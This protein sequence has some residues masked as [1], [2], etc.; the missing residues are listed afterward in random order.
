MIPRPP[1][2]TLFPYT[3]L[4]RSDNSTYQFSYTTDANGNVTRTDVTDP[5]N[6][7]RRLVFN[8]TPTSPSGFLS[9][10]Y[11]ASDTVAQGSSLQATVS[12]PRQPGTNLPASATDALGR[13]TT[14]T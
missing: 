12:T 4:F 2:S 11:D 9:G 13:T 10:A 8:T 3:T 14:Y 6:N 5:R 7:V 1:R